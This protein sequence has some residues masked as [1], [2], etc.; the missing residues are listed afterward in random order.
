MHLGIAILMRRN[1]A[2]E[3]ER[4]AGSNLFTFMVLFH[5]KIIKKAFFRAIKGASIAV[6]VDCTW[7][8]LHQCG[9]NNVAACK[10]FP[11]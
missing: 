7:C 2:D 6:R 10:M 1:M 3:G 5:Y 11:L 8:G 4:S 9:I